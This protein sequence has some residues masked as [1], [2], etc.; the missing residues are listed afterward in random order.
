MNINSLLNNAAKYFHIDFFLME[1]T[2]AA[3][4]LLISTHLK[5]DLVEF[6]VILFVL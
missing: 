5:V 1:N 4:Y 6:L 2:N 3:I